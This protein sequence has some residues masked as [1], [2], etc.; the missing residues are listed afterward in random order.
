MET[1]RVARFKNIMVA[2]R[3]AQRA[4]RVEV[5]K[6]GGA[7][8]IEDVMTSAAELAQA[9]RHVKTMVV[10]HSRV[11]YTAWL[12]IDRGKHFST[13]SGRPS[14]SVINFVSRVGNLS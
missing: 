13:R 6:F 7:I 8:A 3:N 1:G 10:S 4:G 9:P 12:H 11:Q 14:A 5:Q 2:K